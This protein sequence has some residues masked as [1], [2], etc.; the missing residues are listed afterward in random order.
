MCDMNPTDNKTVAN[1]GYLPEESLRALHASLALN[2]SHDQLLACATYY[3]SL[4]R[5]ATAEELRL[6]DDYLAAAQMRDRESMTL[7]MLA[8]PDKSVAEQ[9]RSLVACAHPPKGATPVL[10]LKHCL[11]VS[12][13]NTPALPLA[14]AKT[15]ESLHFVTDEQYGLLEMRG[16][17]PM[18]SIRL[19]DAG[20]R[21]VLTRPTRSFAAT[22]RARG[23]LIALIACPNSADEAYFADLRAF[24]NNESNRSRIQKL[25][26]CPRGALL[27]ALLSLCPNGCYTDTSVLGTPVAD[28]R[29]YLIMTDEA[30]MRT[31]SDSARACTLALTVFARATNDEQL[32]L[33]ERD[34][35]RATVPLSLLRR[36]AQQSVISLQLS[37]HGTHGVEPTPLSACVSRPNAWEAVE[38]HA[39]G[40]PVTMGGYTFMSTTLALRDALTPHD[41]TRA[42]IQCALELTAAGGDFDTLCAATALTVGPDC[43]P[44]AAWSAVLGVHGVLSEYKL[45]SPAPVVRSASSGTG[46]LTICLFARTITPG[47]TATPAQL[48]LFAVPTGESGLPDAKAWRA[49]L[50]L[51]SRAL[52]AGQLAG[53]RPLWNRPLNEALTG[54]KDLTL[55]EPWSQRADVLG[56]NVFGLFVRAEESV[57]Q[58]VLLGTLACADQATDEPCDTCAIHVPERYSLV[59]HAHPTVV[60]PLLSTVDVPHTLLAYLH[61]L[62]V[63]IQTLP[64]ALT[65]QGCTALADAMAQAD[66]VLLCGDE[67][68]WS[69]VLD[70]RRV[71]HALEQ[72][73]CTRDGTLFALRGAASSV[74]CLER[75]CDDAERLVLSRDGISR[76]QLKSAVEYYQ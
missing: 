5:D 14:D 16:H 11:S 39:P 68:T 37:T 17:T 50:S 35:L 30:G 74:T 67:Q 62:N 21:L 20:L 42:V 47:S 61:S 27:D 6:I 25:T 64:L 32:S 57:K 34:V 53:L 54:V 56:Q 22:S 76:A 48:R 10:T 18:Q 19:G 2:M 7:S 9:L 3:R 4:G 41:V 69:A 29:G 1:F 59:H 60:V 58:G 45:A 55:D 51:T 63:S 71:R 38:R 12:A 28:A 65:H 26:V 23:S 46:E 44:A 33:A 70:H 49:M 73:L 40:E 75:L 66:I 52:A 15:G 43:S 36:L 8:S 13:K 31:L 24:L 72:L